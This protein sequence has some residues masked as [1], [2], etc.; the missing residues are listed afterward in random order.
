MT[1]RRESMIGVQNKPVLAAG[2]RECKNAG[3]YTN[4]GRDAD[5]MMK[6]PKHK[7]ATKYRNSERKLIFQQVLASTR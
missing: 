5:T 7:P 6:L 3:E 4:L 1:T 2:I